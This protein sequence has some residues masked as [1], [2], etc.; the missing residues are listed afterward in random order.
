MMIEGRDLCHQGHEDQDRDSLQHAR[1]LPTF[2]ATKHGIGFRKIQR[3]SRKASETMWEWKIYCGG[4]VMVGRL[5]KNTVAFCE[6]TTLRYWVARN[7]IKL[8]N[9]KTE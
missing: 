4:R 1:L 9:V 3:V 8:S 6:K 5:D 2:L 7:G